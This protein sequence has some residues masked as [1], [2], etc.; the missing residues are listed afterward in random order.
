MRK[1]LPLLLLCAGCSGGPLKEMPVLEPP[2]PVEEPAPAPAH[3]PAPEP[4]SIV[5]AWRSTV[6]SGPGSADVERVVLVFEPGGGFSGT[7]F[8]HAGAAHVSGEYSIDD[9]TLQVD[10]AEG[11]VRRWPMELSRQALLLRDEDKEMRLAPLR[12]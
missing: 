6:L 1:I 3:P 2:P 11:D 4:P 10:L 12:P 9:G 5:G 7:A 8:T